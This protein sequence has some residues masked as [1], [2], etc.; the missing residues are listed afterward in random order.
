MRTKRWLLLPLAAAGIA[1]LTG[2]GG[3]SSA[4]ATPELSAVPM[5][6]G[7]HVVAHTRRCDR[8]ANAYC[9]VQLVLVGEHDRSSVQLLDREANHLKSLGW[10]VSNGDT[11]VES[12]SESPGHKLRLTY[13]TAADDL[14]GV[15]LGWIRRSP[16][17]TLALS[18]VMF[19]RDSALSLMLETGS[20]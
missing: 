6:G 9:A 5:A 1:G 7:T 16:R 12:A 20:S 17:I 10:T 2:C 19:N 11:G 4:N 14:E 3:H 8:G 13:A 15:D 18:R